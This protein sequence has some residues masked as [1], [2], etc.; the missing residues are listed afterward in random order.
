MTQRK[1]DVEADQRRDF[2]Q[3]GRV[4]VP[5][6]HP[7]QQRQRAQWRP[8]VLGARPPEDVERAVGVHPRL[9][10][11]RIAVDAR[12]VMVLAQVLQELGSHAR[13]AALLRGNSAAIES[14]QGKAEAG[15]IAQM[16][17]GFIADASLDVEQAQCID[18]DRRVAEPM[19]EVVR[20]RVVVAED[21][22][23]DDGADQRP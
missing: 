4:E 6:G 10:D 22:R 2:R 16:L 23:S 21:G 18:D 15:E 17:Q 5:A 20:V 19:K 14:I 11:D 7:A 1:V 8:V 12:E 3:Q 13:S 9:G